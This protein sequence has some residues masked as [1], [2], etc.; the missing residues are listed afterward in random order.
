[1]EYGSALCPRPKPLTRDASKDMRQDVRL[2]CG[3]AMAGHGL[4]LLVLVSAATARRM[5]QIALDMLLSH[6]PLSI[7]D[8]RHA[9][10]Y[11]HHLTGLQLERMPMCQRGCHAADVQGCA[12]EMSRRQQS[13]SW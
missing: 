13:Y 3:A 4:A 10:A 11:G 5:F 6:S 8:T 12:T 9:K 7:A 1:M 2:A